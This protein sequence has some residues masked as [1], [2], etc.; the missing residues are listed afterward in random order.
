MRLQRGEVSLEWRRR[1]V[2]SPQSPV[3]SPQSPLHMRFALSLAILALIGCGETGPNISGIDPINIAR[4]EVSPAL[5]TL[6]AGDPL[7]NRQ[8]A[9][10]ATVYS[11]TNTVFED[12]QVVWSTSDPAVATID[13]EG[14]L[15]ALAPGTTLV[16]ASAGK[17]G[18]A[19]LVVLEGADPDAPPPVPQPDPTVPPPDPPEEPLP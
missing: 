4:I 18:E 12:A 5:D 8:R 2:C 1:A 15:T 16:F 6:Y 13:S 14:V 17:R 10:V 3:P 19:R 9:Y 7:F 11:R